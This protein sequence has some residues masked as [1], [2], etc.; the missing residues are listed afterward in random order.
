MGDA[1]WQLLHEACTQ[2]RCCTR[3]FGLCFL[4][5]STSLVYHFVLQ[6][7]CI[8]IAV[9]TVYLQ[10]SVIDADLVYCNGCRFKSVR[11]MQLSSSTC[12]QARPC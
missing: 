12:W 9:T 4:N 1:A 10:L 3:L 7:P 5:G 11:V 6:P 8:E 2:H